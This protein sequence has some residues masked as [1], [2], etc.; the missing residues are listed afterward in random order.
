MVDKVDIEQI[1]VETDIHP[2]ESKKKV[3]AAIRNLFPD[4]VFEGTGVRVIR[5]T[6][7]SLDTLK[8][9]ISA[10]KIRDSARSV[11][12]KGVRP[13][14]LYFVVAKQAAF[15]K[16]VSFGEDGPLGDI[17]IIVRTKDPDTVVELLTEKEERRK[18]RSRG[19]RKE[20]DVDEYTGFPED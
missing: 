9:R 13:G 15:A 19:R 6:S 20:D 10:Q 7:K 2:T 11:L 4:T 5:G 18:G 12:L 1:D 16:R 8:E 17:V 14:H 3:K